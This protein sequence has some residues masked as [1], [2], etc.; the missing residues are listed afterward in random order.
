MMKLEKLFPSMYEVHYMKVSTGLIQ[1]KSGALGMSGIKDWQ[2]VQRQDF[3]QS[4]QD[5]DTLSAS[6]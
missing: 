4:S 5:A 3:L 6:L 1:A 2:H